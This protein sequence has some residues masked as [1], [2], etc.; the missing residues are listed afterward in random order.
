VGAG[1]GQKIAMRQVLEHH[2]LAL[3]LDSRT[4]RQAQ[5]RREQWERRSPSK[6]ELL[7]AVESRLPHDEDRGPSK[8]RAG[9]VCGCQP[10]QPTFRFRTGFRTLT[11]HRL[12][13]LLCTASNTSLYRPRPTL[14]TTAYSASSLHTPTGQGENTVT[15][16]RQCRKELITW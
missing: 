5:S 14:R 8:L 10:A 13:V 3:D 1:T 16:T 6:D 15:Q 4:T 2:H 9:G 7:G 11:M 12:P